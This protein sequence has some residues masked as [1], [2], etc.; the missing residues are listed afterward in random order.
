MGAK[1]TKALNALTCPYHMYY[2]KTREMVEKEL[3]NY[4]KGETRAEVV[5]QVGK[6]AVR[7]V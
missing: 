3:V 6:R 7:T 2:Y 1:F 4:E 5:K